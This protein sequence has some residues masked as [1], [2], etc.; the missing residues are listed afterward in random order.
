MHCMN[1]SKD[2]IYLGIGLIVGGL[3]LKSLG[4]GGESLTTYAGSHQ[5]D[6]RPRETSPELTSGLG[7]IL[8]VIGIAAL[9]KN[10]LFK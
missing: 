8:V 6:F 3:Y 1:K 10:R 5:A 9:V 2:H 7:I 4:D